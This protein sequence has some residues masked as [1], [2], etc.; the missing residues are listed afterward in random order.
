MSERDNEVID[1][2]RRYIIGG[3]IG[4]VITILTTMTAF[5]FN[6]KAKNVEQDKRLDN[7]ERTCANEEMIEIKLNHIA[8]EIG[9]I[10]RRVEKIS[11]GR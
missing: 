6:S 9:E 11:Q 5:F 8:N 10:K 7:L 3:I 4:L 2:I 1:I